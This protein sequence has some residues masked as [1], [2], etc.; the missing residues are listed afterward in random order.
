MSDHF[1]QEGLREVF[2]EQI[3][4]DKVNILLQGICYGRTNIFQLKL[5]ITGVKEKERKNKRETNKTGMNAFF[6]SFFSF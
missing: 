5:Y 1:L 2:F 6:F 3:G 4:C